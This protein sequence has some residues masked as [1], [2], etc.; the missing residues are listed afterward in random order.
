MDIRFKTNN[1]E[2]AY[3]KTKEGVRL[4][5]PE[6]HRKYVQRINLIEQA[7]SIEELS[8]LPGLHWHSPKGNRAGQFSVRLTGNFRLILTI[9]DVAP[10]TVRVE[11]VTDYHGD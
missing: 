3:L 11:E 5:G 10:N 8:I 6:I 4:L 7:Q 1:L 2:K 9:D